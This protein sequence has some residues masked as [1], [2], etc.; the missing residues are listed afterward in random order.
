MFA[1][2]TDVDKYI[3]TDLIIYSNFRLNKLNVIA[4]AFQAIDHVVNLPTR[5]LFG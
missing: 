4:L 5:I 1:Q 3:K 2:I